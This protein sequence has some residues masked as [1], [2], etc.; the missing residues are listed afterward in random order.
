MQPGADQALA[1]GIADL[2]L[3][4][5]RFDVKFVREWTDAA[6]QVREDTGAFLKESDLKVAGN[7]KILFAASGDADKLIDYDS[8]HGEWADGQ[9]EL[10][11]SRNVKT[12]D[13]TVLCRSSLQIFAEAAAEYPPPPS[14]W[15]S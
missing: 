13:G 10:F 7:E 6:L 11:T 1:L 15:W 4:Y 8:D 14:G 9:S 5:G 3:Q 2:L 12:K